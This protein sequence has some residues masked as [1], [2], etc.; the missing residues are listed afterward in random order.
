MMQS[1]RMFDAYVVCKKYKVGL[2][3][4]KKYDGR[5]ACSNKRKM[6]MRVLG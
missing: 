6:E 3:E 4:A 2:H 5:S 1:R